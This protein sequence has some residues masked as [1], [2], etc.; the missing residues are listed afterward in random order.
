MKSNYSRYG[1]SIPT[2]ETEID[3]CKEIGCSIERAEFIA[4][5]LKSDQNVKITVHSTGGEEVKKR[6]ERVEQKGKKI[7][8][9]QKLI[10]RVRKG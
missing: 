2:H 1:I 9:R 4:S 10:E 3:I 5:Q 7:I 8:G 6:K